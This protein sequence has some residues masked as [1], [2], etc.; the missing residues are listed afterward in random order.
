LLIAGVVVL[1]IILVGGVV[2]LVLP[3]SSGPAAGPVVL[4][5][6]V[7]GGV[8]DPDT[9]IRIPKAAISIT[10][11]FSL[12][13][14]NDPTVFVGDPDNPVRYDGEVARIAT[15][16]AS[17]GAKVAIGPGLS[18]RLAGETVRVTIE[19]RAARE[20]GATS[21][22]FAYQSGVAISHWQTAN[23]PKDFTPLGL[24]WRVPKLRTNPGGDYLII[25]PGVP[26][27]GTGVE[28]KS[29]K[30]ELVEQ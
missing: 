6:E 23:L 26:G 13:D 22:R 20:N 2:W 8:S 28:I 21:M 7:P 1:A 3:R 5:T 10:N 14:G 12:F 30:I 24:V 11:S 19:A 25:E 27:S 17:S 15:S 4:D 29:V 9:A 18:T 16:V